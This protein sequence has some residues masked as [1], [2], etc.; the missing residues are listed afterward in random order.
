LNSRNANAENAGLTAESLRQALLSRPDDAELRCNLAIFLQNSGQIEEAAEQYRRAVEI[1][2][3][4]RRAWYNLGCL[5]NA[6]DREAEAVPCFRKSI[7]L[8]PA[9]A[10]THHNLGQSLFNLGDTDGAIEQYREAIAFGGGGLSETM[11]AMT[12]AVSPSADPQS[13]LT[14]R[15]QWARE[16]LPEPMWNW[17]RDVGGQ[18]SD[19]GGRT[20]DRERQLRIGY[21]S[22]FFD[23]ANWMKPVWA[24]VNRHDR[25]RFALQFYSDGKPQHVPEGYRPDARDRWRSTAGMSNVEMA[26]LIAADELDL[27]VDLNGFSRLP[28]LAVLALRP[29]PLQIG[30]FNMFAT[31]GTGVFDYL[32]GDE[33]VF[34][35]GDETGYSER[36][37]RVG[38]CYLTFEVTYPVPDV[39]PPPCQTSGQFTFGSLASLYKITPQVVELWAEILRESPESRLLLRNSGFRTAGNR[40]WFHERFAQQGIE[41]GRL[42]LQGSTDHFSFLRTYDEIDLAL[43]TFPYN[44]GTT[45]TEALWQG[46]PVVAIHGDRWTSRVSSS[47][48]ANTGLREFVTADAEGY[49]K[50]AV[51]TAVNPAARDRLTQLRL[52]FRD[53]L[54]QSDACDVN[55]FAGRMEA[56]YV[57]I[58]AEAASL[59]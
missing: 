58:I 13:I 27:L 42:S 26:R 57:S 15:A 30:W 53:R 12:I 6:E 51:A 34:E 45:T 37:V 3:R 33:K 1:D 29:A 5:L 25:E 10:P 24:L 8:D 14:T 11:L 38:G 48:L 36:V 41:P 20:S 59:E 44:G 55:G 52:S 56:I 9:H 46:V 22:A 23:R 7:A 4:M 35:P 21:V 49:A 40:Q 31:S 19:F 39:A 17:D 47:L 50:L 54:R 43:D 32:I 2:P 18:S 16:H 28:R